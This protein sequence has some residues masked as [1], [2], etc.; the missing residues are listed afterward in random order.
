MEFVDQNKVI[1]AVGVVATV[2]IIYF[3]TSSSAVAAT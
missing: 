3:A 1:I 2:A